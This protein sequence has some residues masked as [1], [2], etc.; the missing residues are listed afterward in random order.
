MTA[1]RLPT[2][3]VLLAAAV[4]CEGD[5]KLAPPEYS[6]G[7]EIIEAFAEYVGESPSDIRVRKGSWTYLLPRYPKI[8]E[9]IE[10][11]VG[12]A[13]IAYP[14]WP[15]LPESSM[16]MPYIPGVIHTF[17]YGWREPPRGAGW[18]TP[19]FQIGYGGIR[20]GCVYSLPLEP[21]EGGGWRV[22]ELEEDCTGGSATRDWRLEDG[23][24]VLDGK[25]VMDPQQGIIERDHR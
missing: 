11:Y 6:L 18:G 16:Y 7:R 19:G 13:G 12:E 21:L 1:R 3:L 9:A 23:K 25:W 22:G 2:F 5:G 20:P 8:A 14:E 10:D 15:G 24:W 17:W 4:G